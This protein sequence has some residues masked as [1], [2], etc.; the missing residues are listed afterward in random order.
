MVT[1][2]SKQYAIDEMLL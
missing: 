2:I 1:Y